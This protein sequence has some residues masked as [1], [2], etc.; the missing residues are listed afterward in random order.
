MT[1]LI[2]RAT[3]RII[4]LPPMGH[5]GAFETTLWNE[6]YLSKRVSSQG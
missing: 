4:L 5:V 2:L 3:R 6:S 1:R